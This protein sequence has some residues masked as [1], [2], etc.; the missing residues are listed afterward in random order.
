MNRLEQFGHIPPY[1]K[2]TPANPPLWTDLQTGAA[3][4]GGMLMPQENR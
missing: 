4:M 2:P 1:R 3:Q